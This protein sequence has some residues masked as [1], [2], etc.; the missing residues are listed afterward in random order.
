VIAMQIRNEIPADHS[1]VHALNVA[2]FE[3]P[4]EADLVEALRESADPLISLVAVEDEKLIGHI[5][6]S[7]VTL[8]GHPE[9]KCMGLAPMAVS[10]EHQKTGVGTALITEGLKRCRDL[11][12][13]VVVV[14]GHPDYYP[15]FGFTPTVEYGINSEYDVPAEVFMLLELQPDSL[16]GKTGTACYHPVFANL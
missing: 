10:A 15:R 12:I 11:G 7:P 13:E 9:L 1:S 6:Y 3:S 16:A 14:L 4:V 8:T 5:L 2:A